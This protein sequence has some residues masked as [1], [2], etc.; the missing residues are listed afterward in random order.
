MCLKNLETLSFR[1]G[2]TTLELL[3]V[4]VVTVPSVANQNA[5]VAVSVLPRKQLRR[6][7]STSHHLVQPLQNEMT[8]SMRSSRGTLSFTSKYGFHP[9]PTAP[10]APVKL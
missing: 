10:R 3:T 2:F 6:V 9:N 5:T 1:T 8:F 4:T 7:R